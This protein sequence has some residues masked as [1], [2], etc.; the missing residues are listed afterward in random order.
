MKCPEDCQCFHDQL[1]SANVVQ[2]SHRNLSKV[3]S[4][5]PMDATALHLNGNNL[6]RLQPDMFLGRTRLHT[7]TI[8]RSHVMAIDNG[9][10]ADLDH[11]ARLHLGYNNLKQLFGHEFAEIGSLRELYLHHNR[12]VS[13]A[14]DPFKP[15]TQLTKL[16]LEGNL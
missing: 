12:L 10:F 7:I 16:R 3:P 13:I 8:E 9:T 14:P 4:L 11:L 15:L 1:W 5:V 2:C 6:T